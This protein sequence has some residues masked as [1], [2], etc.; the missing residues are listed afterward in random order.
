MKITIDHPASQFG[1]PVILHPTG[2][3][4][5]YPD[6]IKLLKRR[7]RM[8]NKSLGAICGV[9]P[10]TAENWLAGR[11][12]PPAAALNALSKLPLDTVVPRP[13]ARNRQCAAM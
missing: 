5:K 4:M 6:G 8:T 10:R 3:V 13:A 2:T 11:C 9:A 12:E 7:M 1:M